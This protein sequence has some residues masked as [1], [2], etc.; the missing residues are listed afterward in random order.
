MWAGDQ[1]DPSKWSAIGDPSRDPPAA[2]T[3]LGEFATTAP[4]Q[5][6]LGTSGT[7]WRVQDGPQPVAWAAVPGVA[8]ST[9]SRR[10]AA[11]SPPAHRPRPA[12]ANLAPLSPLP[13]ASM[14]FTVR[15]QN[16]AVGL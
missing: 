3:S 6:P 14:R 11:P 2:H 16:L 1:V 8:T 4:S 10:I 13:R 12:L 7:S 15:S 9:A 5:P